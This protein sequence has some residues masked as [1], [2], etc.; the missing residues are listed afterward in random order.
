MPIPE[1]LERNVRKHPKKTYLFFE[2]PEKEITQ[3]ITFEDFNN[4][5]NRVAHGL[6]KLGIKKGDKVC[7]YLTNCPEF[8]YFWFGAEKM[9]IVLVTINT[10][11][12]GEEL[13]YIINHSD[14]KLILTEPSF[15]D[16]IFAIKEECKHLKDIIALTPEPIPDTISFS[17]LI[18]DSPS[19]P[20]NIEVTDDDLAT[21]VYTSGTTAQPKGVMLAHKSYTAAAEA[22]AEYG[23]LTPEDRMMMVLVLYHIN[24]QIYSTLASLAAGASLVMVPKFSTSRYWDQVRRYKVTEIQLLPGPVAMLLNMPAREEDTHHNVRL[25]VSAFTKEMY[26]EIK[27]RFKIPQIVTGFSQTECP[28]GILTTP[29]EEYRNK[30]IGRPRGTD[31]VPMEAKIVDDE[32]KEVPP[33]TPGELVIKSPAVMKGYYKNPEET[34]KTLRNGWLHTGDLCHMDKDGNF[35]FADRLKDTIRRSEELIS[36]VE[37][38]SVLMSHPKIVDAAVVPVPDKIR[39]EEVK[40]YLVTK[41]GETVTPEEIVD[42]CEQRLASFKVPRYIAFREELP[43]TAT[44]KT[45]KFMLRKEKE[46]TAGWDREKQTK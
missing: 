44:M 21:I 35:Y 29:D 4:I 30:L 14:G 38:E 2:N 39:I 13:K 23:Q 36:S 45:R 16:T 33:E 37:L 24:A 25:A 1:L 43:K 17:E 11:L 27:R 9:G 7:I 20:P 46:L 22:F 40:A 26:G 15:L 3:E 34:A 5:S 8:L 19:T 32:D 42:Y 6:L 18:K 28:L 31:R 10:S 12:K 41:P